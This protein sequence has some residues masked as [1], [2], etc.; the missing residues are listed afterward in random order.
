MTYIV[1]YIIQV[2]TQIHTILSVSTETTEKGN[3]QQESFNWIYYYLLGLEGDESKSSVFDSPNEIWE[4]LGMSHL[5]SVSFEE[6][7][8]EL[9]VIPETRWWKVFKNLVQNPWLLG[10]QGA[11]QTEFFEAINICNNNQI[12]SEMTALAA[13]VNGAASTGELYAI[14]GGNNKLIASA[15]AQAKRTRDETCVSREDFNTNI[16]RVNF[17][18]ANID[19]L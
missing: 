15:F 8:K 9:G 18:S 1:L 6:Y 12:N 10:E 19:K 3:Q 2:V 4:T 5:A 17:Q 13:L 7:L 16:R 14:E 11:V